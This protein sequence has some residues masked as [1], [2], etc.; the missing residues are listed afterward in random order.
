MRLAVGV[1]GVSGIGKSTMLDAH[2]A[3]C[4]VDRHIGGSAVVKAIIAPHSVRDLDTWPEAR[5]TAVRQESIRRLRTELGRTQRCLLVAGH[6]TLRSRATGQIES[7]LT[8]KDHEFFDALVHVDGDAD[9]VIAQVRADS[10]E[11]HGQTVDL[12]REHL[13]VERVVAEETALLMGVPL[14]SIGGG[15]VAE[16]CD[17]LESFLRRVAGRE[18]T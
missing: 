3:A 12:V 17:A 13:R 15:S 14:L 7:I 10:R 18:L 16:R 4:P 2:V 1:F 6:F 11:R 5:R 8:Q 9:S